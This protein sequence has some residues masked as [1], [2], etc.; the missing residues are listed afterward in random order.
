MVNYSST[1]LIMD[2]EFGIITTI[3]TT[4]TIITTS[5]AVTYPWQAQIPS[6][7]LL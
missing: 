5:V 4:T 6:K 7:Q 3:T 1:N 2:C